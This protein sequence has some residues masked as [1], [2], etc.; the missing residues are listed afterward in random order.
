MMEVV[1]Q[2][3]YTQ[4]FSEGDL[5]RSACAKKFC[6]LRHPIQKQML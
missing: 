6:E 5:D 3:A 4:S 1:M 2:T